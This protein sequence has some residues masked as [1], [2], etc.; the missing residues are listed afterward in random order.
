MKK[1]MLKRILFSIF[2]LL[3]VTMVVMALVYSAIDRRVIFQTDD[4]WNK[5]SNND[6]VTYEYVQFQKYGY[7]DYIDYGTFLKQKYTALYG[8]D[9]ASHEDYKTDKN[10]IQKGW[11]KAKDNATVQEFISLYEGKG[12]EITYLEPI[13]YSS[14][15]T[16]PGGAGALFAVS[17]RNSLLRLWDYIKGFVSVETTS[18]VQ[19]PELT[20]R[21]I[22]VEKDPYSGLFA[23][24]GSGTF[25]KYLLY[26][27]NRF[28][29]IHQNWISINLGT[30]FT[31]YRGSEI[32][33][34][35]TV[36]QGDQV[37]R[38]R[39]FPLML[40]TD[41]YVDTAMDFHTATY[42]SGYLSDLELSQFPDRYTVC[43]VERDG[44]S[45]L[46]N[47][48]VIGLIA[49]VLQYL[50]GLPLGI[51][52]ARRKDKLADKLGN[53]YIIFIMAVPSL[54]YI[55]MFA[56]I[57]TRLFGLPYKFAMADV[58]VLAYI[59][60]VISLALPGI[61][62]LMKWMRR[63]MIDQ[64][65]SDY[66]KFA[67]AEGLSE[68]EIYKIHISRNALIPLVHGIPGSILGCLTG[69]IITER[70]YAVPGVG[71]L[72]TTAINS[73]DN[74]VIVGCTAFY[75]SLSII[76]IILGDLLMAKYDPRISLS[77]SKGG[78]R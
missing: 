23:V 35:I 37:T 33:D 29:F 49:T 10:V 38:P 19:D 39:Q 78:G 1:Y 74:G 69:A 76:S 44:L 21:Y 58:K 2:S 45:M 43:S 40:G 31:T 42:N 6:R 15:K 62:G 28:P 13:K 32:T 41:E 24:V 70:V 51:L 75:T 4:I 11:D 55:F 17:E 66:V 47:S 60:P 65:N 9:Y 18:M 48:F 16:K 5:K 50:F 67:R 14:G 54:A 71:N 34:V 73:H 64:M 36:P 68:Q 8:D 3:V 20:D 56:A 12:A 72:L 27:D 22:R 61:G 77:E 53:F 59:L 63:Y 7:V 46:E 26:F 52:M 57:G 25:H 30:S